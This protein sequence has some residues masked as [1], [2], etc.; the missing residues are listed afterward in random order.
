VTQGELTKPPLDCPE[1]DYPGGNPAARISCPLSEGE[2][3]IVSWLAQCLGLAGLLVFDEPQP[4]LLCCDVKK[5]R[6]KLN[7]GQD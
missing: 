1:E 5:C 2:I 3:S 7:Y 6:I 4:L